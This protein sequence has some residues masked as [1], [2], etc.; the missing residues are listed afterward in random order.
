MACMRIKMWNDVQSRYTDMCK[1]NMRFKLSTNNKL[2]AHARCVTVRVP[3]L[4]SHA[5]SD[6]IH[7]L[8]EK[9]KIMKTGH[10]SKQH[11]TTEKNKRFID[12]RQYF[13]ICESGQPVVITQHLS[14][15]KWFFFFAQFDEIQVRQ[16]TPRDSSV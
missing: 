11:R 3:T 10:S 5:A 7:T 13:L 9:F 6:K 15:L 1:Y 16:K 12:Q 2:F 14:S 4:R 8:R